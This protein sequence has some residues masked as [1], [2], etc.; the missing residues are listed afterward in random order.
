MDR[1]KRKPLLEALESL[2]AYHIKHEARR[3]KRVWRNIEIPC[4]LSDLIGGLTKEEM[5]G[6]S[7]SYGLKRMS[8]LNKPD[9]AVK[10]VELVPARFASVLPTL[11]QGRYGLVKAA[12]EN[13]GVLKGPDISSSKAEA[14]LSSCLVFPG[15]DNN[16]KVL[17]I[18]RELIDIFVQTDGA[19]L[20]NVIKRNTE[21]VLLTHGMLYYYGVMGMKLLM[22]K[23]EL[24]TG[25]EVDFLEYLKVLTPA[26]EYYRKVN[27]SAY[28]LHDDRVFDAEELVNEHKSRPS[29][30]YY[31]FTKQ[32]LLKAG[33]P[34]F[35]DRTPALNNFLSFLSENY[36]LNEEEKNVI[37]LQLISMINQD[38]KI[39]DIIKYL[40]SLLEFPSFDF[41]QMVTEKMVELY[42]H[43]RQWAL[44][45]HTP[46]EL[47]QEEKKFLKPLP[48]EPFL[49]ERTETKVVDIKTGK[50]VGRND[51]CPCGSGKKF[52]KCCGG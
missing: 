16:E 35:I 52:K 26:I 22:G 6:I 12:V 15:T 18:P 40:G 33:V 14:L 2:K 27:Y 10:L 19:E 5:K 38:G 8:A 49:M 36:D 21:W 30:D 48:S 25:D 46:N 24:L 20:G 11:D 28:G 44:K 39:D 17:Y 13:S 1:G 50:K 51:P 32:Q 23:I 9:L 31:P 45:G 42:N 47:F 43:T 3:E 7:K 37:A 4:S 41:V 34:D 29:V